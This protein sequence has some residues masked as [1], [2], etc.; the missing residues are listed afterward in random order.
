MNIYNIFKT[1][2]EKRPFYREWHHRK[3]YD[4]TST[5]IRPY[6]D[7]ILSCIFTS[8]YSTSE[9]PQYRLPFDAV[10]FEIELIKDL[11]VKFVTNKPFAKDG[12]TINVSSPVNIIRTFSCSHFS[13]TQRCSKFR[14][15]RTTV[16]ASYSLE[17]VTPTRIWY[18]FLK[19]WQRSSASTPPRHFFLVYP[20]V[21]RSAYVVDAIFLTY[22]YYTATW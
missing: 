10:S 19:A 12:F 15:W 2:S 22:P 18:R 9:I 14:N 21:V 8:V 13:L 3:K 6:K 11:G 4:N 5:I 7:L 16:T 17:S 1:S 20:M